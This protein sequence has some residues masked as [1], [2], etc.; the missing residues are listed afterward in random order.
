MVTC[1]FK[2]STQEET[3]RP[4][5][6]QGQPGV[7]SKLHAKQGYTVRPPSQ[8]KLFKIPYLIMKTRL[9]HFPHGSYSVTIK[10]E[11]RYFF[12]HCRDNKGHHAEECRRAADWKHCLF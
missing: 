8:N 5:W 10:T 3:G 4:L 1:I 7:Q 12:S 6:G 11:W 2:P 9:D